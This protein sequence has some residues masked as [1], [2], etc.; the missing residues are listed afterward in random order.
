MG[1]DHQ[2]KPRPVA[3]ATLT[4]EPGV[5]ELKLASIPAETERVSEPGCRISER[6]SPPRMNPMTIRMQRRALPVMFQI[7]AV[8][9]NSASTSV[10]CRFQA[11]SANAAIVRD[12][13]SD[14]A[15]SA[16]MTLA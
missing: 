11:I 8:H 1:A 16:P 7:S 15:S 12:A 10:L 13:S 5:I 14:V 9:A 3:A 2:I 6:T 4:L